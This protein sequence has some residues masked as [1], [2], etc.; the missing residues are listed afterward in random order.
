MYRGIL[1]GAGGAGTVGAV[2]GAFGS[3]SLPNTGVPIL[4]LLLIALS[5]IVVGAVMARV[6][7]STPALA[8]EAPATTT[9]RGAQGS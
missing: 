2:G 3:G 8:G 6:A 5:M 4:F 9:A 7:F 1:G